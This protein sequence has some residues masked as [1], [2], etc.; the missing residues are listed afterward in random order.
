MRGDSD[1]INHVHREVLIY[2]IGYCLLRNSVLALMALTT[3]L[4]VELVAGL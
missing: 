1:V 3:P 4:V 2:P